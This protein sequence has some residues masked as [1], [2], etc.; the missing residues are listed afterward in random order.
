M[1]IIRSINPKKILLIILCILCG[2]IL[3]MTVFTLANF[4]SI[5]SSE[6]PWKDSASWPS[7]SARNTLLP[8]QKY[9]SGNEWKGALLPDVDGKIIWQSSINKVNAEAP[10]TDGTLAYPTVENARLG[11]LN[12]QPELGYYKLLTTPEDEWYLTVVENEAKAKDLGL[13]SEFYKTDFDLESQP[14]YEGTGK[15]GHR[16]NATYVGWQKVTLPASWQTQGFDFPAY[17]NVTYPW[18]NGYG[19]GP[20]KA[21]EPPMVFNP[22]GFYRHTFKVDTEWLKNGFKVY[23]TFCGV[24]SAMYLY[25][26]GHEVGYAE[27]SFDIHEFDITPF[28]KTDGSENLLAVRVH[29]WSDGSWLEDQDMF[30][31]AGIFRDVYISAK[32]PVHI[33]DYKITTDLDDTFTNAVLNLS[34]VI[35]NQSTSNI[36][37]FGI[38]IKLFDEN[39]NNI[40]T[41]SPLRADIPN[42]KSG[43]RVSIDL[44][45][46]IKNPKK[47]TDETP[48]LYTMVAS[49]YD[50]TSGK[51]FESVS[52]QVGFREITF[53]MT[54]VDSNYQRITEKY[55][56]IQINGQRL[57]FRGVNRHDIDY[58]T[59]RYVSKELY[60]KDILLMKQYNINA[61]RTSHYPNDPYFYYLCDKYGLYVMAEANVETHGSSSDDLQPYFEKAIRDN[62]AANV[63]S[64]K[65][66]PSVV[67]WSLGNESQSSWRTKLFQKAIQEVVRPI[68]STRPVHY[69]PLYDNGGVDVASNMY[70]SIPD[71]ATRANRSDNM[72]YVMCEYNHA[73]GNSV[74]G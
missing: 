28:L 57:L 60:E 24:E 74:G 1:K 62:I 20:K 52:K 33:Q 10:H 25:I 5:A 53:T 36:S 43:E 6:D 32:P 37:N 11:A 38:D 44:N 51:K 7:L 67:M 50:K 21:P 73:M 66:Y 49:L 8:S 47:W 65:N 3:L 17:T 55:E 45:R 56:Q 31:L 34:F 4:N 23:M 16:D 2:A 40:L 58:N 18:D 48:N 71:T 14:K 26:N 46:L 68:D 41:G 70:P 39:G 9:F 27:S 59:G 22:I 35:S 72:P 61:V 19:N 69:E 42:I 30:S 12:F 15:A 54:K 63:H 64:K 29:R 13:L